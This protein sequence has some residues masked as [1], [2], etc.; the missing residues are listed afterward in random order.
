VLL[1]LTAGAYLL[2]ESAERFN[3]RD[4]RFSVGICLG[5]T[6]I[7]ASVAIAI[8][9]AWPG[10]LGINPTRHSYGA[11]VWTL[12]GWIAVHIAI[13]AAMAIW[14]GARLV[15][16]MLDSWRCVTL[17]VCLLWWRFTAAAT[18]LVLALVAGFPYVFR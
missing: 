11:A 17:R 14:C 16:R 1:G 6:A 7:L 12:L 9:S 15:L 2:F 13:G 8:G 10:S 4:S 5:G 3:R 18:A